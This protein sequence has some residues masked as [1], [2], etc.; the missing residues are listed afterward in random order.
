MLY[1]LNHSKNY[2]FYNYL[3]EKD[4]LFAENCPTIKLQ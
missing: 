1:F 4:L 3:P 2:D